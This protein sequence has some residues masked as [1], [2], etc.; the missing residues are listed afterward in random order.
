MQGDHRIEIGRG[1]HLERGALEV[2]AHQACAHALV[3]DPRLVDERAAEAQ[4]EPDDAA[5]GRRLHTA[6]DPQPKIAVGHGPRQR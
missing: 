4:P 1:Q 6:R 3:T 2:A 5:P